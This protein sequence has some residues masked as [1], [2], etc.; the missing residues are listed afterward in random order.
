MKFTP[1]AAKLYNDLTEGYRR[2]DALRVPSPALIR[3]REEMERKRAEKK[4]TRVIIGNL[5]KKTP[6]GNHAWFMST[7]GPVRK[8]L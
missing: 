1:K 2:I 8:P 4:S 7:V 6:A 3:M 5:L